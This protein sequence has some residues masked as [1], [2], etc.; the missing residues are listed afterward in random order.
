[1]G[2]A[3]EVP[4]SGRTCAHAM[5]PDLRTISGLAPKFSGFHSTRSARVPTATCPTRWLTP[6]VIALERESLGVTT[7]GLSGS[8]RAE[9]TD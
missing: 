2:G 1:M 9:L 7:Y 3:H 4:E 5:T 6:C 8:R